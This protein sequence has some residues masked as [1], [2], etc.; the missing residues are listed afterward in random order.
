LVFDGENFRIAS[1]AKQQGEKR[2]GV[3]LLIAHS[4][5]DGLFNARNAEDEEG[6]RPLEHGSHFPTSPF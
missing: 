2:G 4:A 3:K 1:K 6:A 5:R